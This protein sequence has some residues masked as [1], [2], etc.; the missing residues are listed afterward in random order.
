MLCASPTVLCS[1]LCP[2]RLA[3]SWGRASPPGIRDAW[4]SAAAPATEDAP[5]A[6]ARRRLP[7]ERRTRAA[8]TDADV[9]LALAPA[10]G[11][12]PEAHDRGGAATHQR[13]GAHRGGCWPSGSTGA[14]LGPDDDAADPLGPSRAMT[15]PC[16]CASPPPPYGPPTCPCDC[17]SPPPPY[18]PPLYCRDSCGWAC[19]TS[20][21]TWTST[22]SVSPADWNARTTSTA[23]AS[24]AKTRIGTVAPATRKRCKACWCAHDLSGLCRANRQGNAT[25]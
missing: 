7:L 19:A 16:D 13:P 22:W 25:K 17:A 1:L 18:G 15:C 2:R 6:A 4:A 5:T 21:V 24:E 9:P 20:P 10:S 14:T 8:T 23:S 12:D 3:A 11:C